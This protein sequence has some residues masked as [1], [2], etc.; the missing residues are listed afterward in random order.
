MEQKRDE[1]QTE[2]DNEK[3]RTRKL[4]VG[5]AVAATRAGSRART[6]PAIDALAEELAALIE[7]FET[8]VDLDKLSK[9]DDLRFR[10]TKA[11]LAN[12]QHRY[13]EVQTL[14][15]VEEAVAEFQTAKK[16]IEHAETQTNRAIETNQVVGDGF[17]GLREWGK[18]L[19]CYARILELRPHRCIVGLH[20]VAP[21]VVY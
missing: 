8:E 14:V 11:T 17:Y 19:A 5:V 7:E 18:A 16:K 15:P 1:L 21:P 13:A 10:L 20:K 3:E 12:A 2:L 9:V 6:N 4:V